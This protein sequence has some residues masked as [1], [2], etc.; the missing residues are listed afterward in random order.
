MA[1]ANQNDMFYFLF[2]NVFYSKLLVY[3]SFYIYIYI[4]CVI[5]FIIMKI[6]NN[7]LYSDTCSFDGSYSESSDNE[8]ELAELFIVNILCDCK[9]KFL[10]K[11]KVQMSV[12]TRQDFITELW[13]GLSIVCYEFPS[14]EK[15]LFVNFYD[16]L[17]GINLLND[18]RGVILKEKSCNIFIY[19]RT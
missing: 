2:N 12:L 3:L 8:C 5:G 10:N 13:N 14:M 6:N 15:T 1:Y 4:V 16:D 18:S 9:H 19:H 17:R 7:I 11:T